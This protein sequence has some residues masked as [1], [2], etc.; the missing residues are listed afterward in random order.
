M[1]T[2]AAINEALSIDADDLLL[3]E[4][5][6]RGRLYRAIGD[7]ERALEAFR[8]AVYYLQNIRQ[9]IPIEYH[10]GHSSFRETLSPLYLALT[11][12]LLQQ[13][14]KSAEDAA[15]PLLLEA[16][17][18]IE[19]LKAAE[20]QDYLGDECQIELN[21]TV[22]IGSISPLT[23]V[24]YPILLPDRLELLL[25]IGN[26]QYQSTLPIHA[27]VIH[28]VV[29]ELAMQV[30]TKPVAGWSLQLLKIA[31]NKL[32]D[33][34]IDPIR[35]R[36][37][38]AGVKTLVVVPDGSLRLLPFSVLMDGDSFLVEHYAIVTAP[39]LTLMAP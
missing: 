29:K 34:L 1:S 17:D 27:D 28:K 31:A 2:A 7:Q 8:R 37:D 38:A 19:H 21:H 5:W 3:R 30:R 13:A 36:L 39:S 14:A 12:L 22:D 32:Y 23:G 18:T 11:D 33:W 20:L 15:Q 6:Q 24:L 16:R 9:D 25:G 10:A 26:R 35:S 4:E